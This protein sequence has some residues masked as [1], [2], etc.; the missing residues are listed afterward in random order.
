MLSR[1]QWLAF[2]PA[3][4]AGGCGWLRRD[5]AFTGYAFVAN[6]EGQAVAAVDLSAFAVARHIRIGGSPTAV[7]TDP[8]RPAV[9]VLTPANGT[10]HEIDTARLSFRRKLTVCQAAISMR[11]TPAG[12]AIYILCREPRR[13]V[14]VA[15]DRFAVSAQ[16]PLP[17]V[18]FDFD[19]APP[20]AG[21]AAVSFSGAGSIAFLDLSRGVC[22][23]PTPVGGT[24]GMVRFQSNGAALIAANPGR[25]MLNLFDT[26]A[27]R[28]IVNLPLAVRPDNFCFGGGGGQLF[29]T[30]EGMDAVVIVYPYQTEVAK[31]ILAG[32]APGAMAASSSPEY[33]FVANPGSGDV[34]VVDIATARMLVVAPVGSEPGYIAITPN[35]EYAL[36]LNRKS[37][38][39][40][41]IRIGAIAANRFKPARHSRQASMFTLIPVGSKPV[42][43][44]V[45]QL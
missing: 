13:L 20:E 35:D 44:V 23:R 25:R 3:A 19:L 28:L 17:E 40:G 1:R 5:A 29:V 2:T 27:R 22:E 41:V 30:G 36:V 21:L 43:A 31:T 9:Y 10:L 39:M 15:L 26:A 24:L 18:P 14:R 12:D 34:T 16:I 37:G 38:D 33:L 4:I 11:I 32:R 6:E 8:L 7:A 42:A 45:R